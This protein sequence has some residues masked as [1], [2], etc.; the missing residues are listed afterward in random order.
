MVEAFW[1][2]LVGGTLYASVTLVVQAANA[3]WGSV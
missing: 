2:M 1:L 3:C